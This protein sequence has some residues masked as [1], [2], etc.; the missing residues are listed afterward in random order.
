M[1]EMTVTCR[2]KFSPVILGRGNAL[3]ITFLEKYNLLICKNLFNIVRNILNRNQSS[4]LDLLV[5]PIQRCR[6][7][8]LLDW[9]D[10][11]KPHKG[12]G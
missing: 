7:D 11:H 4:P 8:P 2:G 3:F 9:R 1:G 5:W 6:Y 12:F 10:K